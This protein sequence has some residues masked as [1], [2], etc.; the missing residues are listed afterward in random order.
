VEVQPKPTT[1]QDNSEQAEQDMTLKDFIKTYCDVPEGVDTQS[2]ANWLHER[3]RKR[4]DEI[5]LPKPVNNWK[6]GQSKRYH[7]SD[8]IENWEA[9]RRVMP[10]LPRLKTDL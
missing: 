8:L 6:Q 5:S 9:Y 1:K 7:P 2:K 10:T 4:P 3:N